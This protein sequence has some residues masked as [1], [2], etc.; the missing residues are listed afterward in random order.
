MSLG[1]Q[2][3]ERADGA[4]RRGCCNSGR[5]LAEDDPK[6]EFV[7]ETPARTLADALVGADMFSGCRA[8]AW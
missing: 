4:T 8:R 5:K 6:R 7:R 1:V 3:R 2:A